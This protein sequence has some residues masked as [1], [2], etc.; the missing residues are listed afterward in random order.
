[1]WRKKKALEKGENID[2]DWV[3]YLELTQLPSEELAKVN[4][5]RS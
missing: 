2:T 1:M 4:P 3:K 5:A